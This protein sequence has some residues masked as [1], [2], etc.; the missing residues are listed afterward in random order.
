[1]RSKSVYILIL[2][3]LGQGLGLSMSK[4]EHLPTDEF[5]RRRAIFITELRDLNACAILHSAP[6]LNRNKAVEFPYRQDSDFFYLTGWEQSEAILLITPN[7]DLNGQA[8]VS[9]FAPARDPK[10][11]VWTGPKKD[12]GD[13]RNLPGVDQAMAYDEFYKHLEKLIAGY[14]RLVISYGN[15]ADF[16]VEFSRQLELAYTHPTI[17][18]EAASILKSQRMIK[19]DREIKSLE[20]AIEV[21]GLAL[22]ATWPHIPSLNFEYEVQAEIEYGFAKRGALRLAFPSIVGAGKNTTFLHYEANRGE[23]V[24]GDLILTDIGAEWDYYSADIT[25]TV[26]TNGK[27][28]PEQTQIYQLVLDAQLAA[29]K[30]VK[31]GSNFRMTHDTAVDVITAGLIDLGL[32][33]GELSKLVAEKEYTKFFMHGTSHWLGL[34]VHD[35]G[36]RVDADGNPHILKAG[37]VL[38]VEPGIYIS[39][40]ENVE[41]RWWNIGVRIEDDVLVTKKGY[42][43]LS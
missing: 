18:Q 10:M 33:E 42:R 21:T 30:T 9:I 15:N 37:M 26:P 39:E 2:L 28:S 6:V 40:S 36:G 12:I 23:L 8:Q 41:P 38:T 13:A 1:M 29:I 43:V 32:L 4:E 25:R 19:S 34:D 17:I 14:E 5:A 35:V 7:S 3:F 22:E 20:K 11:E 31:P 27:F 24:S 16:K